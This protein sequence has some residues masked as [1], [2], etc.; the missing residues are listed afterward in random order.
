MKLPDNFRGYHPPESNTTYTPNQFFDVVLPRSS[1]GVVRLVAYIIRKTLG[2]CD[3]NGNPQEP[4]VVV[5]YRELIENA[6]IG[7]ARIKEAIEEAIENRYIVCLREARQNNLGSIGISALYELRWDDREEYITDPNEFDGFYAGNGNLTY[8]PNDF[9][10]YTI[11]NEPLAVVRVVGVIIRHTIGFQTRYGMRRQQIAMP[12][13]ELQNR[14]ELTPRSVCFAIQQAL[15]NNH[16]VKIEDGVFDTN[17]GFKSKA[18]IYG[19]RWI[20]RQVLVISDP[21]EVTEQIESNSNKNQANQTTTTA[22]REINGSKSIAGEISERF[23]KYSGDG[24]KN[25]V[26]ERF[27]KYS[28]IEIKQTN[29]TIEIQQQV[30]AISDQCDNAVVVKSSDSKLEELKSLLTSTGFN[31]KTAERLINAYPAERIKRQVEWLSGRHV[32]HNRIG[33]LRK[34]IEEDWSEPPRDAALEIFTNDI[35]T[36]EALFVSHFYAAWAGNEGEPMATPSQN[37]IQT[38]K[39]YISRLIKIWPDESKLID[40]ARQFGKF[41]KN[42][43]M[44]NAKVIRSFVVAVRSHGDEFYLVLVKQRKSM[45]KDAITSAKQQHEQVF[46]D[47]YMDY[48]RNR[49]EEIQINNPEDYETFLQEDSTSRQKLVDGPF[50]L[51]GA[52]IDRLISLFDSENSRQDRFRKYCAKKNITIPDFWQW[53]SEMNKESFN[54]GNF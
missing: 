2:W 26:E 22:P 5:S 52:I 13:S 43:E 50:A 35:A 11:P 48:L 7:R 4:H 25:I 40:W 44:G 28:D 38:A 16:I 42:A 14:T 51:R 45:K 46:T 1:R 20:D 36:T 9:F 3:A 10:D 37:D 39:L 30:A 53:D 49:E 29:K 12:Y 32:T 27:Q 17:A 34:A 41:V 6:G 19:I 33:M 31:A 23:Q 8:I 54:P 18:T 47:S 15:E 24:S 21:V